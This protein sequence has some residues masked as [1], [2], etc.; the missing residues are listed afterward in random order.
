LELQLDLFISTCRDMLF[1]L[2]TEKQTATDPVYRESCLLAH[3]RAQELLVSLVDL[4]D[5]FTGVPTG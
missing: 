1:E 2:S 3:D 4:R 5:R